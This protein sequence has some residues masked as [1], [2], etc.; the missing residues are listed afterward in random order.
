MDIKRFIKDAR[1]SFRINI[2][3]EEDRKSLWWMRISKTRRQMRIAALRRWAMVFRDH[4]VLD[5]GG[6]I[7]P[8]S[9]NAVVVDLVNPNTGNRWI[10][11]DFDKFDTKDRFNI[12]VISES[13]QCSK[14]P[15]ALLKKAKTWLKENGKL[16]IAVPISGNVKVKWDSTLYGWNEY[17]LENILKEAGFHHISF[18]RF[19]TKRLSLPIFGSRGKRRLFCKCCNH[20]HLELDWENEIEDTDRTSAKEWHRFL[21]QS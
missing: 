21:T 19:K 2:I 7:Y 20:H 12:V 17:T 6:G 11:A 9:K 15:L 13:L 18:I 4:S 3:D 14:N 1:A 16:V 8:I 10:K 5:V